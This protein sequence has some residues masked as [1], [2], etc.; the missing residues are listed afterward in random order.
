M[1]K[2]HVS[3]QDFCF[4]CGAMCCREYVV[5]ISDEEAEKFSDNKTIRKIGKYWRLEKNAKT[6]TYI[7]AI[8]SCS[9][10]A[11]RPTECQV[12]PLLITLKE[13]S[14][15]KPSDELSVSDLE[16]F[17]DFACPAYGGLSD[18]FL[19][20]AF[21]LIFE[22]PKDFWKNC[23]D[24]NKTYAKI[25]DEICPLKNFPEYYKKMEEIIKNVSE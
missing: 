9:I 13:G 24:L 22:S 7:D 25:V 14:E 11:Q 20:D 8:G 1:E 19:E 5:T 4:P 2:L 21:Y 12:Y 18:E 3:Q 16:L 23:S 15:S 17:I 6:C 10:Y